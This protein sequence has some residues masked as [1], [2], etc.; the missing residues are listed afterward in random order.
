ML[1]G[2]D[3]EH[4]GP[5]QCPVHCEERDE[6]I[7]SRITAGGTVFGEQHVREPLAAERGQV[8]DEEREI[9]RRH[10]RTQSPRSNSTQSTTLTPPG[11]EHDVLGAQIAV[12]FPH[13]PG[14]GTGVEQTPRARTN[15]AMKW[16]SA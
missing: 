6:R 5:D 13:E 14:P 7:R 15:S 4:L 2:P 9:V 1:A 16:P 10:P 8:H 3:Q 12:T 11:L